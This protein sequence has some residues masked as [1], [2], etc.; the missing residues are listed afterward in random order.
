MGVLL[1]GLSYFGSFVTGKFKDA[2]GKPL[3]RV[4][5]LAGAFGLLFLVGRGLQVMALVSTYGSMLAYYATDGDLE[6]VKAELEKEPSPEDLDA[7]VGRAAQYDNVEALKLLLA[8]GA[9][10]NDETG[11]PEYRS[12]ILGNGDLSLDFVKVALDA[13]TTAQTCPKPEEVVYRVV[14]SSDDAPAAAKIPL[15]VAAGFPVD[16]HPDYTEETPLAAAQKENKS[17]T[18]AALQAA[19]AQ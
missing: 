18:V 6:D 17:A 14:S 3:V 11:D 4:G 10:L 16:T 7:A 9:N 13:G 12:C 2:K 15:L 5:I 19:G 1:I 8:A